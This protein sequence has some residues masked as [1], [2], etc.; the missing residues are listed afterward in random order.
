MEQ[1]TK[2][3]HE[4]DGKKEM[5]FEEVFEKYKPLCNSMASFYAKHC[6]WTEFDDLKQIAYI[7]LWNGY[8]RYN[9]KRK[10]SFGYYAQM[11]V[12][13]WLQRYINSG[14]FSV[15]RHAG[16]ESIY[17]S[18]GN[19]DDE[20]TLF[21]TLKSDINVEEIAIANTDMQ[22]ICDILKERNVLKER[23]IKILQ[24]KVQGLTN[25]QIGKKLGISGER[26]RQRIQRIKK[27][28]KEVYKH[29]SQID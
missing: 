10:I 17:T 13:S 11:W 14:Q 16:L 3:I 23:D 19:D 12:R 27:K 6:S 15:L 26:V 1:K 7:G 24:Y 28:L 8:T 5:T 18:N 20:L 2:I 21:D 25:A 29:E 9:P 22:R 4:K